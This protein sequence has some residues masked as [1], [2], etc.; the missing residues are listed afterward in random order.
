MEHGSPEADTNSVLTVDEIISQSLV[1]QD[2][3][4]Y[5]GKDNV[6]LKDALGALDIS[7]D[8]ASAV[9]SEI[10]RRNTESSFTR[11]N[12]ENIELKAELDVYKGLV[13][14]GLDITQDE[15]DALDR[16]KYSDPDAWFDK[17]SE[18]KNS[19]QNTRNTRTK[20]AVDEAKANARKNDTVSSRALLLEEFNSNTATPLTDEQL[21]YDIPPR[22]V[23]RVELGEI[24]F[25]EMLEQA[26]DFI[27][28]EKVIKQPEYQD[29]PSFRDTPGRLTNDQ[30]AGKAEKYEDMTI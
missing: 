20:A 2:D 4:T 21:Q 12:Q 10:R 5:L 14:S 1:K 29:E 26:H 11:T 8:K 6:K 25:G 17:V 24:T 15:Q 23:R 9:T 28:G 30:P 27:N 7:E 16:L 22:L 19:S 13:P 18:L 3:G